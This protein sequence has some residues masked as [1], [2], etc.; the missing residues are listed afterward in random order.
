METGLPS[1]GPRF[2]IHPNK[3]LPVFG[4][5]NPRKLDFEVFV[6]VIILD[7][8]SQVRFHKLMVAIGMKKSPMH[9]IVQSWLH[10][11]S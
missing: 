5:P 8:N 6:S 10:I 7:R 4:K 9:R 1:W 2:A 3:E 11:N